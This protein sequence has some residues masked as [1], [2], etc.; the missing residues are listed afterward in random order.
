MPTFINPHCHLVTGCE[1][2]QILLFNGTVPSYREGRVE[3]CYDN[4]Y[5]TVCDDQWDIL[6]AGV[7]CQQLNFSFYN[8]IPVRR[9]FYGQ[10]PVNAS[11]VLDNVVCSGSEASLLDCQHNGPNSD[12][13]NCDHSE[14]AGVRCEGNLLFAIERLQIVERHV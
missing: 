2:G 4:A 11:I 12:S 5:G 8:A 7:V 1:N 10:G 9:A 6:D 13:N 14:D 3:I